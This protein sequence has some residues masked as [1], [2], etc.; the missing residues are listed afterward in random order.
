MTGRGF[1]LT[2]RQSLARFG[3]GRKDRCETL[4]GSSRN[5]VGE[6][7]SNKQRFLANEFFYE[8]CAPARN[9]ETLTAAD[10]LVS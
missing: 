2:Q 3:V 6:V 10:M 4:D 9:L 8:L 7:Y 5:E 1:G